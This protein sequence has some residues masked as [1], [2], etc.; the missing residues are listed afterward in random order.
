VLQENPD[1]FKICFKIIW[2]PIEGLH[3]PSAPE[4]NLKNRN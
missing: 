4:N 2:L 3:F 1:P